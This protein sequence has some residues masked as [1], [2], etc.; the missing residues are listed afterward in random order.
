MKQKSVSSV[1]RIISLVLSVI[2]LF[3]VMTTQ[4]SA[5]DKVNEEMTFAVVSGISYVSSERANSF[6]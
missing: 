2:M 4:V 1:K 6:S 5:Q 3:A